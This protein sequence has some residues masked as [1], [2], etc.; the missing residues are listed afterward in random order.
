MRANYLI[1]NETAIFSPP[2]GVSFII[3]SYYLILNSM[4]IPQK[5]MWKIVLV[6]NEQFITQ[7]NNVCNKS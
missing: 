5:D 2:I 1:V 3:N 4:I 6:K 7:Y